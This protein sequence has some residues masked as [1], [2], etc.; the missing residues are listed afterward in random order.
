MKIQEFNKHGNR[1]II[2]ETKKELKSL[3]AKSLRHGDIV[4]VG[5]YYIH[6]KYGTWEEPDKYDIPALCS[7]VEFK[8]NGKRLDCTP[9]TSYG[10]RPYFI[11][12]FLSS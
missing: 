5:K 1:L 3:S 9:G 7:F 2:C 10:M 12:E 4:E 8:P 6:I 11:D